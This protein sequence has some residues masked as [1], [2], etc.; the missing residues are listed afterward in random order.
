MGFK[1]GIVGLPNVGKSTLFNAL[2]NANIQAENYPFCTIDPNVGVVAMPDPRLDALAA[3]VKP[4]R[5]LP[6]SM[7]FVDIAGLVAG[8]SKGEGLGNKFLANIRETQAIAHVVRCFEND[9]I[10]HVAGKVN[11][12]ADIEVIHTELALADMDTVERAL[13]RVAKN[14]KGGNK[15]ALAQKSLFERVFAQLDTGKAVRSL[16]LTDEEQQWIRELHLLT[17]KPTVYIANVDENGFNN[18]PYLD[19]VRELAS[20]ENA[21]VVPVCAKTESEL[22]ALDAEERKE[23][24]QEMGMD[25]PGLNRV[26]HAGYRLLGLQ[27][28]FTAGEKEVRAWTVAIGATAPQ[29]AAVIHTDFE[30]GFI[31]AEVIAYNDFVAYKG[32]QGAKEAGKWRLEG[33]EYIV[34]DGDVMHFRFN[35]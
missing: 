1:C 15:E 21:V 34:Q 14:S 19:Q 32:E 3:I 18:N 20:Q 16:S 10:I 33:K 31:R 23:F 17:A 6:T 9:D 27:T 11:P 5:I 22:V 35:V 4:Q 13:Q 26:I 2:T 8:A 28:Y 24:L 12:L 30:K 7:E 29:A 25:E